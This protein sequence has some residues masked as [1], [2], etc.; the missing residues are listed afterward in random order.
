MANFHQTIIM[1]HLG[2]D[3]ETRFLPNGD[4][5]CNFSV[6]VTESWKSQ[7][8]QKK[9]QTTWYR[10]NAFKKLAEICGE[11]LKKGSPVMLVGKMQARKYTNKEGAEVESWELRADTI[12]MLG[13]RQSGEDSP[14]PAQA[15]KPAAQQGG[16]GS[17]F[18]DGMDI[19]FLS[20]SVEHDVIA[21]RLAG[22]KLRA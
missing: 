5:V 11:Y 7:D 1:G 19:P 16:G 21:R 15:A 10:V 3:P 12:Q 6:A 4:A 2:R 9:E 22:R 13:S 18:D 14:R 17:S 20:F 8:G